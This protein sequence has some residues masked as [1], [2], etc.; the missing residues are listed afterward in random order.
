MLDSIFALDACAIAYTPEWTMKHRA[1]GYAKALSQ[2]DAESGMLVSARI[3]GQHIIGVVHDSEYDRYIVVV[4]SSGDMIVPSAVDI[5][6]AR[7][8][9]GG[10]DG[11]LQFEADP[12]DYFLPPVKVGVSPSFVIDKEGRI[13]ASVDVPY[14][15]KVARSF[16]DL[17]TGKAWTGRSGV[18]AMPDP[19]V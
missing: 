11:Q 17:E 2:S 16:I 14:F 15:E 12:S 9:L 1:F 7:D 10:I 6:D 8:T 18:V 3:D 4:W 5:S 13:G 19:D